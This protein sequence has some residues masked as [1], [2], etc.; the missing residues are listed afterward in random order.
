MVHGVARVDNSHHHILEPYLQVYRIA[1]V[2]SI[3]KPHTIHMQTPSH[4]FPRYDPFYQYRN[5]HESHY[6]PITLSRNG[7]TPTTK[8]TCS[9]NSRRLIQVKISYHMNSKD[10]D[11]IQASIRSK[12]LIM[13]KAHMYTSTT[14]TPPGIE[15]EDD[16]LL[17]LIILVQY[18]E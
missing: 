18:Y 17:E 3:V 4:H 5:S 9:H 11:T 7:R 13:T 16:D 14:D 2:D 8:H 12:F 1:E 10:G 15:R 6:G